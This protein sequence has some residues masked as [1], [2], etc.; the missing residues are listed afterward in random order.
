[1]PTWYRTGTISVTSGSNTVTGSGTAWIAAVQSGDALH[2]PDGRV[3]EVSS[4]A[5]N[6]TLT[7][8]TNYSGTS[9]SG[10]SYAIQPTRG[11]LQDFQATVTAWLAAQAGYVDGPLAG[12]WPDGAAATPA[13][14]FASDLD[15]GLY[16][17]GANILGLSAGGSER[18]RV[19]TAGAQVTGLLTGTAVTQTST[20]TTTGRL[21]KVSDFGLGGSGIAPPS[22][23]VNLITVTGVYAITA[24]VITASA[25]LTGV[26]STGSVL[27][28]MAFDGDDAGQLMINRT[29]GVIWAR[30]NVSGTWGTFRPLYGAGNLLGTVSQ[31]GGTPTGAVIERGSSANGEY[32][33]FADGTQICTHAM[34]ASA[35]AA[36]T[37][38]FPAA[39]AAAPVVTGS[40]QATVLSAVCLDAVPTT[41]AAT[42]S[43]RDK[44]D[45]RRADTCRLMAVG[46]WF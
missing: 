39:F 10:Q 5:S 29:T 25:A 27:L 34:A 33:R 3:Y 36:A 41:T 16:R 32:V 35:T 20:D 6:A 31:S 26:A 44:T 11:I 7:L 15:T 37:W 8:A 4:V 2:A 38:T 24:T 18:M 45:A 12:K 1:M 19:T 43:A 30:T 28:H 40:A 42:F 17:I 22:N 13:L 21:L 14:S 23:D 46:R 9:Q